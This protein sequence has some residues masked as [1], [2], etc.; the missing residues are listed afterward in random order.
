M[1]PI[2]ERIAPPTPAQ[3]RAA[4]EA[5]GLTQTQAATLI[6]V[7][8]AKPYRTWQNYELAADQRDHRDIP[9]A[10]WELFLL[11]TDQH[12]THRMIDRD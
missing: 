12:P 4:R 10:V 9:L 5:A 2:V 3:V 6:S 8:R 7:S 11:L 1:K